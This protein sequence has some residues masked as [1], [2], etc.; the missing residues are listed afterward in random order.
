M[1]SRCR[2][3]TQAVVYA[4]YGQTAGAALTT[5]PGVDTIT[6]TGSTGDLCA[7]CTPCPTDSVQMFALSSFN[8]SS[9]RCKQHRLDFEHLRTFGQLVG[10]GLQV[11]LDHLDLYSVCVFS[12]SFQRGE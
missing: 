3:R 8:L 9:H 2:F 11:L 4:G 1:P 10:P 12:I 6:F 5:H 7:K